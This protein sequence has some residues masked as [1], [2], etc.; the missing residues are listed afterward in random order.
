MNAKSYL[1]W[2]HSRHE[3][4]I[5]GNVYLQDSGSPRC[6]DDDDDEQDEDDDD[7]EDVSDDDGGDSEEDEEEI[8]G[9]LFCP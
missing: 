8:L 9:L 5:L 7:E 2:D 6:P 3:R 1:G 4:P